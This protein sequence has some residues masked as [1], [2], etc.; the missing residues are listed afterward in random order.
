MKKIGLFAVVVLF[1]VSCGNEKKMDNK[2]V[3]HEISVSILPQKYFVERIA[4]DLLEVN[5]LIPPGAS[6]ATYE[7][8]PSQLASLSRSSMYMMMG[9][10]GFEMAWMT[11]LRAANEQMQVVDLSEGI[12]LIEEEAVHGDGH[13]HDGHHHGGIDPHTWLS[14]RNVKVISKNLYSSLSG[15]FPEY[16]S[17]FRSNFHAFALELDSL[18]RIIGGSLADLGSRA[19]YSYH[20]SLSYFARDYGLEQ[21]SLEMG[22]KAPSTA[23]MKELI[24]MGLEKEIGVVFLQMQ[25]D[26]HNAKVLANE[27]GAKIV[28][29]NPLDPDWY[30]QMLYISEKIKEN[31]Q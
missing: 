24:D 27:I 17:V 18:D 29:I 15:V 8:T 20:P 31:L 4:G 9:Y 28:Q 21:Y 26:Q 19:F 2:G 5:V 25:F 11:K 10:S 23:H 14:P 1:F 12:D 16:D 7:P 30:N 13:H 22:G 3:S 6:P